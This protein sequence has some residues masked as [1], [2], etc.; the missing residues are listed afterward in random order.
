[1]VALIGGRM[2]PVSIE[3]A[4]KARKKVR[5]DSDKVRTAL[6]IGICLGVD[7]SEMKTAL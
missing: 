4:I 2:V 3:Q 5:L 6:D 7:P 1:M